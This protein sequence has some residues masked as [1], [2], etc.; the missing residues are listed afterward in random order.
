MKKTYKLAFFRWFFTHFQWFFHFFQGFI[1][2]KYFKYINNLN[3]RV[4]KNTRHLNSGRHEYLLEKRC[5]RHF[6]M[7]QNSNDWRFFWA[8]WVMKFFKKIDFSEWRRL[9]GIG[10]CQK[11]RCDER[12]TIVQ[13]TVKWWWV[14]TEKVGKRSR[15]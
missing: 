2:F 9:I 14:G 15:K 6:R 8:F 3:F 12:F 10:K 1:F 13:A 11:H 7:L 5:R 4:S